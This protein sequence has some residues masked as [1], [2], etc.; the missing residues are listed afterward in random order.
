MATATRLTLDE[1]LALPETE[2][3]SEF[4]RGEVE[5]KAMPSAYHALVVS[6][7]SHL[8][9][10]FL[11]R[12]RLALVMS[13]PRHA[14]RAEDRSYLPD[15]SV[16]LSS[17]APSNLSLA[18]GPLELVPDIAIEVLSPDD[19]PGRVSEKVAFY[20]RAGTPIVW[21]IDPIDRTLTEHR[22]VSEAR[23]YGDREQVSAAPI[24]PGFN[25]DLEELFSVLATDS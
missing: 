9:L 1:F 13:D 24:L 11:G 25:L 18:R 4:I 19:R 15:V 23:L 7:L 6:Q 8:F 5:Q 14:D 20:L 17:R 3:P 12:T 21:L 2:P 10:V 16:V 22:P